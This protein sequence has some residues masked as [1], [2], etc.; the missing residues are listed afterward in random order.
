MKANRAKKIGLM[1]FDGIAA[2]DLAGPADAFSSA[3]LDGMPAYEVIVIG[4]SE[5]SIVAESG[6]R[7]TPDTTLAQC[8]ALDTMIIPGGSGLRRE[9]I[10]SKVTAW[11]KDNYARFRRV[12]S[13]C[14]GIYALAPTGL[15]DGREVT[16]HWRFANDVAA[17][18]PALKVNPD[19]IFMKDGRF[20]TSAGVTAGI[21]LALALIED[22][23]GTQAA[24]AVA[25]E[26]VVYLKRPGN[27]EQ[28]SEPLRYQA[29]SGDRI[30]EMGPWI[31][32]HLQHDLTVEALAARANLCP[33]QF[34]RRFSKAFGM[35]PAAFVDRVRLDSARVRLAEL[36]T[37]VS[38]VA[39]SVGYSNT[40]SFRRAFERRFGVPPTIYRHSFRLHSAA[41]R[42]SKGAGN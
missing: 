40:D 24:M 42:I 23:L 34:S 20:Y 2:L 8:G 41:P 29:D 25:R 9:R 7:I 19:A 26:L 36:N 12:A 15:L 21:D 5:R 3:K 22:D 37:T 11:L 33:R 32:G 6:V 10:G 38:S 1:V 27:Q 30:R 31:A 18:F 28:Y 4:V 39:A 14:T 17:K 35:T 16:T 13:I